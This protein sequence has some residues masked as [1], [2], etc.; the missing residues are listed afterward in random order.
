MHYDG[1]DNSFKPN[2]RNEDRFNSSSTPLKD[3]LPNVDSV[4]MESDE[5]IK[6]EILKNSTNEKE[7]LSIMESIPLLLEKRKQGIVE[8]NL[9]SKDKGIEKWKIGKMIG[10]GGSGRVYKA[11]NI[12]NGILSA[13]KKIHLCEED[14]EQS[15]SEIAILSKIHHENIVRYL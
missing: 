3:L 7:S 1:N 13:V 6:T 4:L 9:V 11:L 15:K 8:D 2:K 5:E 10:G 14:E 12:N